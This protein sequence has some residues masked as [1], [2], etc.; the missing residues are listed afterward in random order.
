MRFLCALLFFAAPAY[1]QNLLGSPLTPA[2][3]SSFVRGIDGNLRYLN[4]RNAAAFYS[5]QEKFG[6]PSR[7]A[8]R[9]SLRRLQL[10]LKVNQSPQ[11]L[12]AALRRDFTLWQPTPAPVHFTGYFEPVYEARLRPDA[13]FRYP[14]YRLPDVRRWPRPHPTRLQLEGGDG[15]HPS[16]LL[17]G[18]EL[19]WLP[20]RLQAYLVQ[21]EGAARLRLQDHRIMS[22]GF[23]GRTNWDYTGIGRELVNDGKIR[24]KDLTQQ[25]MTAYFRAHPDE[26]NDYLPRNRRFVFL[27]PTHGQPVSGALGVSLL[28]GH[29]IATDKSRLP[30]GA[31]A[32]LQVQLHNPFTAQMFSTRTLTRIALDQDT[33]GAIRGANRVDVF[34]GSGL[35]AGERAGALNAMGSLNY[36]LLRTDAARL[37][38]GKIVPFPSNERN[39]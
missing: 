38:A 26:L 19:A 16:P 12:D 13:R 37:R 21:V 17:R 18:Y 33:G 10:L 30:P 9:R 3:R 7:A 36:L 31:P 15:L 5:R 20:D 32:L 28:A 39:L 29:S 35:Q 14:I 23:A 1:S 25:G 22:V 24:F 2:Q 11:K 27:R 34:M 4:S 8:I 6:G